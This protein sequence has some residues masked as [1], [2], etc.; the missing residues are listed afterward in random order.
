MS[1][2]LQDGCEYRWTC[3]VYTKTVCPFEFEYLHIKIQNHRFFCPFRFCFMAFIFISALDR[4]LLL[5]TQRQQ[6]RQGIDLD[7][8]ANG[9][10]SYSFFHCVNENHWI[11]LIFF[12]LG[13]CFEIKRDFCFALFVCSMD[14]QRVFVFCFVFFRLLLILNFA[15]IVSILRFVFFY[16]FCFCFGFRFY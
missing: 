6:R 2:I 8:I 3:V 15:I 13:L 11:G 12:Y 9:V 1:I 4:K 5:W 10:W 14:E 16:L 7:I